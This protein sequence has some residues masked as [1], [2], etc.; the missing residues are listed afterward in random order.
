M[1]PAERLRT[2]RC[3]LPVD[4]VLTDAPRLD[5]GV[6]L[7]IDLPD[8]AV[9]PEIGKGTDKLAQVLLNNLPHDIVPPEDLPRRP[10]GALTWYHLLLFPLRV[11]FLV[12]VHGLMLAAL[13]VPAGFL[14]REFFFNETAPLWA[15]VALGSFLTLLPVAIAGYAFSFL[16]SV[17]DAPVQRD[18]EKL[19]RLPSRDLGPALKSSVH[20]AFPRGT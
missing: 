9:D 8:S 20:S 12:I 19:L 4:N 18:V 15:Q 16:D 3:V 17:L 2:R 1:T 5:P 7:Y 11:C 10:K 13:L 6:E 14:A